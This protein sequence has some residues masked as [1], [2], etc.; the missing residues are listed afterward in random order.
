MKSRKARF[1]IYIAISGFFLLIDQLLK[2]YALANQDYTYYLGTSWFGW[3]YLG[4]SGIAFSLQFPNFLLI[5][6]TPL[7]LLTLLLFLIKQNLEPLQSLGIL[8]IVGGAISNFIDR[9]LY[10]LTIDYIRLFTS[11]INIADVMIVVGAVFLLVNEVS[12]RKKDKCQ[13]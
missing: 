12:A 1:S 3:E 8:L 9:I 4:N 5:L 2:Q 11:V 10:S 13:N 7:V 6:I